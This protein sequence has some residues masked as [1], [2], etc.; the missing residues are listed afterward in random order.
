MNQ[1][2]LEPKKWLIIDAKDANLG[3]LSSH[4]ALVLRGKHKKTFTPHVNNGDYVIV[5]N[6]NQVK[7]SGKKESKKT[8]YHHSLRPGGLKTRTVQEVRVKKPEFLLEHAFRLMLPKNKLGAQMFRQ[9][10]VYA[11]DHHP[12]QAQKPQPWNLEP[13]CYFV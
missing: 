1:T 12:H 4:I 9:L 2:K 10:F 13:S 7:F 8:Y 11:C 3:R 5:I 6:A